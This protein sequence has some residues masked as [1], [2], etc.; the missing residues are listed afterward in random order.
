MCEKRPLFIILQNFEIA[1]N[2]GSAAPTVWT[3]SKLLVAHFADG[4]VCKKG[5]PFFKEKGDWRKD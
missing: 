3:E 1:E 5:Y 4:A 2:G